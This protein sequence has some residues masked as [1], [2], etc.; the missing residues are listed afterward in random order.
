MKYSS[1]LLR[2]MANSFLVERT[3][4]PFSAKVLSLIAALEQRYPDHTREQI[5]Q[6]IARLAAT[7]Q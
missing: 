6:R 1:E 7:G 5:L 4:H 3:F 2:L